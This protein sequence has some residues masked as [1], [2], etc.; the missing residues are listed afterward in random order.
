MRQA[1]NCGYPR[2]SGKKPVCPIMRTQEAIIWYVDYCYLPLLWGMCRVSPPSAWF[3]RRKRRHRLPRGSRAHMLP[4]SCNE[5]IFFRYEAPPI[6]H[7][8]A[9]R[10]RINAT[11]WP[12]IKAS[13][14]ITRFVASPV[15]LYLHIGILLFCRRGAA[16]PTSLALGRSLGYRIPIAPAHRLR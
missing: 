16:F 9:G 5:M 14:Q 13:S 12:V 8:R 4:L 6:E 11:H 3:L 10:G 2:S 1:Q 15:A 7:P